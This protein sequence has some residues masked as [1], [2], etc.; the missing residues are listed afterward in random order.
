LAAPGVN[1]LAAYMDGKI[2]EDHFADVGIISG[3]SMS[4][5]FV[6]GAAALLISA[7]R[8]WTPAE[9]K[10]ALMLTAKT[11]GIFKDDTLKLA[12]PFDIGSG[13][14]QVDLANATGLVMDENA[15]NMAA[16]NPAL[17]GDPKTLNLVTMQNNACFKQ[18]SWTRSFRSVNAQPVT[19][20]I[21]SPAGMLVEP[22]QFTIAPGA[23][24]S[25]SIT[26]LNIGVPLQQWSFA[27]IDL[28]P[29]TTNLP[30]LHLT[31]AV[32]F[33]PIIRYYFP[34]LVK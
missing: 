9:V 20:I 2:D 28:V 5:P 26:A 4:T 33:T 10:S 22:A 19:Y 14:I 25:L 30:P 29:N 3:T 15:T 27:Q 18:C 13:R 23:T 7:H 21:N 16:A 24:Q 34:F 11:A 32:F 12:D 1:I 17:G 6:A 31:A 8:D